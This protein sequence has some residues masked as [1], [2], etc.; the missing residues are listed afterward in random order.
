[1]LDTIALIIVCGMLAVCLVTDLRT[2]KIYNAVTVPCAGA[3]LLLAM[4][5]AGFSGAGDRLLTM[6]TVFVILLVLSP[7]V[8]VGGGDIKLLMAVGA[9]QGFHFTLWALLYTGIAG[10]ILALVIMARRRV[11]KQTATTMLTNVI[12]T[13]AGVPTDLAAGSAVGKIPY[14]L[15]IAAGVFVVLVLGR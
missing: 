10:G 12:S 4:F 8:K 11:V 13:A 14:S 6:T 15:A 2:G 7:L 9:L 1:M 3:G 5:S